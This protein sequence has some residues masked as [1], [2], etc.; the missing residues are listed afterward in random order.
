MLAKITSAESEHAQIAENQHDF[1]LEPFKWNIGFNMDQKHTF[2]YPNRVQKKEPASP[3]I[4]S[5]HSDPIC[6]Q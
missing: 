5:S 6:C 4:K 3:V 2:G 1:C